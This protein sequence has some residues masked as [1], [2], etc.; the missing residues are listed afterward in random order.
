MRPKY[1]QV[2]EICG[3]YPMT[4][5]DGRVRKGEHGPSGHFVF[6]CPPCHLIHGL[7]YGL[8]DMIVYERFIG[9]YREIIL[10]PTEREKMKEAGDVNRTSN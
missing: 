3:V 1:N 5:I 6:M 7:G 4:L 9:N 10:S 2:C 8:D